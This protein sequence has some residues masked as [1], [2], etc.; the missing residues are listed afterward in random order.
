MSAALTNLAAPAWSVRACAGRR[1]AAAALSDELVDILLR[2]LLD[3]DDTAVT[4]DTAEAL[5]KR[6][7]T[8][9]LRCILVALSRVTTTCTMDHLWDALDGNPAWMTDEGTNR[10]IKQLR[11]LTADHDTGVRAEANNILG[12]LRLSEA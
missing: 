4:K 3:P 8:P 12:T 7:D 2:L 10:L 6:G 9:G 5:L 11:E 1:L